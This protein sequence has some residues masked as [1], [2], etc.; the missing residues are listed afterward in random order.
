VSIQD[1]RIKPGENAKLKPKFHRP[2]RITKAL[3][4]SHYVIQDIPGFN[5]TQTPLDTIL[6]SDRIKPWMTIDTEK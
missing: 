2:Y 1:S 3:G 5:Y 4:N 6:S